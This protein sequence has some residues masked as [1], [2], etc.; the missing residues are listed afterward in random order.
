V[1]RSIPDILFKRNLHPRGGRLSNNLMVVEEGIKYLGS[2]TLIR[3]TMLSTSVY[4]RKWSHS[5][6]RKVKYFKTIVP[7]TLKS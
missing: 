7:T 2:Y 5:L 3:I 4:C 6:M 1:R